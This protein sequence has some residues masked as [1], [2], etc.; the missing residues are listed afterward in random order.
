MASA[1]SCLLLLLSGEQQQ[2]QMCVGGRNEE[3]HLKWC[4]TT[5]DIYVYL[6]P[7]QMQKQS[8]LWTQDR[9]LPSCWVK[10]WKTSGIHFW[11]KQSTTNQYLVFLNSNHSCDHKSPCYSCLD[12]S[13]LLWL[14]S[15]S[16]LG[17]CYYS[18]I[19]AF[20]YCSSFHTL[21]ANS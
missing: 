12:C 17:S 7:L 21:V 9:T 14:H 19:S 1:K 16:V 15:I 13:L 10:L 3:S 20:S 18:Q 8:L 2:L 4:Q 5:P 11:M 6:D